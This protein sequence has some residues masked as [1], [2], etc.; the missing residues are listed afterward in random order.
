M[1]LFDTLFAEP[2]TLQTDRVDSVTPCVISNALCIRKWILDD[3]GITAHKS[4]L[5][6]AT[7]LVHSGIGADAGVVFDRHMPRKRCR[8]GHDHAVA[9]VTVVRDMRLGHKKTVA[10]NCSH[11][12]AAGRPAIDG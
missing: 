4:M 7:K 12:A 2:F 5:S 1:N 8:I 11:A 10:S 3:D 6:R 9:Y